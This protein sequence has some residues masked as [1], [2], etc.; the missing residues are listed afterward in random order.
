MHAVRSDFNPTSAHRIATSGK[1]ET[2]GNHRPH[3]ICNSR[4]SGRRR[5]VG[6]LVCIVLIG[7]CLTPAAGQGDSFTARTDHYRF[8]ASAQVRLSA[9]E[10]VYSSRVFSFHIDGQPEGM[11]LLMDTSTGVHVWKNL[12]AFPSRPATGVLGK[13]CPYA[14]IDNEWIADGPVPGKTTELLVLDPKSPEG[15]RLVHAYIDENT[16]YTNSRPYFFIYREGGGFRVASLTRTESY[17]VFDLLIAQGPRAYGGKLTRERVEPPLW[18]KRLLARHYPTIL[19]CG[20]VLVAGVV[21][22]L[23]RR[24]RR[25]KRLGQRP[26]ASGAPDLPVAPATEGALPA[27]ATTG[28]K[29]SGLAVNALVFGLLGLVPVAGVLL[30][31]IGVGLGVIVLAR[32]KPGRGLAIA[33][34]VAGLC[35]ALLQA[36]VILAIAAYL[37]AATTT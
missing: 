31:L 24:G 28:R 22:L 27:A 1:D 36:L 35:T 4:P 23:W 16:V 34:L 32:K 2:M 18:G 37:H 33:G 17:D 15:V 6:G 14:A 9:T 19:V 3:S 21:A 5:T 10:G 30:G 13:D 11:T 25:R 29:A 7:L 8:S 26:P 12:V 20:V